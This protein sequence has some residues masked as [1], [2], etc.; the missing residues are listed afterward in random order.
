MSVFKKIS[1]NLSK[2]LYSFFDL[3]EQ[4]TSANQTPRPSGYPTLDPQQLT[5]QINFLLHNPQTVSL[6]IKAA[7][8]N[9]TGTQFLI[10]HF[11]TIDPQQHTVIFVVNHSNLIQ[12]V[13]FDQII[14]IAA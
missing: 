10:G 6:Q 4:P 7:T 5:E 13:D 11:K 8:A 2:T 9:Q 12:L 14:R 1:H 3:E